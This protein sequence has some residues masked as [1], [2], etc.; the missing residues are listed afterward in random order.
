MS[1]EDVILCFSEI[2]QLHK[3][4]V[5]SWY[6]MHNQTLGPS[7]E[8]ILDR[9]LTIF[10]KLSTLVIDDA[11]EFYDKL[12]QLSAVYLLPL[13][14]FDAMH[15]DFNLEGLCIPGV[16]TERYAKCATAF[17]PS[18]QLQSSSQNL[19]GSGGVPKQK[20][21]FLVDPQILSP[22]VPLEQPRWQ[23]NTDILEFAQHHELYFWLQAKQQVYFSSRHWTNIFLQVVA[24]LVYANIVTNI[25]SNIDA[26]RHPDNDNFFPQH[27]QL[28]KI[29]TLIYSNAK[30]RVNDFGNPWVN[31]VVG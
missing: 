16:S 17:S 25:Q 11:I 21:P 18:C 6:N 14:P 3:K 7:V 12:Q 28:T 29:A 1:P 31:Q 20:Q 27:F 23:C 13:M 9:G 26:Y 5:Q 2:Q 19:L 30:A 10:P 8:R 15:L 4:V 24:S 22:S